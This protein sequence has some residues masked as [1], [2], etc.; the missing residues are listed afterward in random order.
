MELNK[1]NNGT[2]QAKQ[3]KQW[4]HL[5]P[6]SNE[7]R[8]CRIKPISTQEREIYMH[9]NKHS[10]S[11][12]KALNNRE[13]GWRLVVG[14]P[15]VNLPAQ[16]TSLIVKIATASLWGSIF[17]NIRVH[18][19]Y[20][21]PNSW[22][23]QHQYRRW[24]HSKTKQA[25]IEI[26]TG[27]QSWRRL[28]QVV[29]KLCGFDVLVFRPSWTDRQ[30]IRQELP[31]QRGRHVLEASWCRQSSRSECFVASEATFVGVAAAKMAACSLCAPLWA[32][33]GPLSRPHATSQSNAQLFCILLE[34]ATWA[35]K[36][37]VYSMSCSAV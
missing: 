23:L 30:S 36:R 35:M 1:G 6:I 19:C 15:A 12:S 28:P 2:N 37:L 3:R 34:L 10:C 21:I 11:E 32:H 5:Y 8:D 17:L 26:R 13:D 24:V 7:K 18:P 22:S 27:D 4:R 16:R 25:T 33:C 9:A 14:Q 20:K 29:A 31:K